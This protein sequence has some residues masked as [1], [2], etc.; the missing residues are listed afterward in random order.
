VTLELEPDVTAQQGGG[1]LWHVKSRV[2]ERGGWEPVLRHQ[3]DTLSALARN[4]RAPHNRFGL[5]MTIGLDEDGV[6]RGPEHFEVSRFARRVSVQKEGA[7]VVLRFARDTSNER[8]ERAPLLG[9]LRQALADSFSGLA[10]VPGEA[11]AY[12]SS[13]TIT[14]EHGIADDGRSQLRVRAPLPSR[15]WRPALEPQL[16]RLVQYL[17]A[18]GQA[19][20]LRIILRP[21]EGGE[22]RGAGD[23]SLES[24]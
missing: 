6:P 18:R 24:M 5:R 10:F 23:V 11:S 17:E 4:P 7:P 9:E 14:V 12:A 22:V 1:S 3:A 21:G 15:V 2:P 19:S 16:E 13:F 20:G 8:A